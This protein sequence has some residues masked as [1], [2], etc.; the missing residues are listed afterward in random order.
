MAKKEK[1]KKKKS[2][3]DPNKLSARA[4][5]FLIALI[6][7]GLIFLPTSMLLF[8]GMMPSI[9]AVFISLRGKGARASTVSAMN[10]AGC[11]PY[12]FK[13]WSSGNDFDASFDIITDSQAVMVM[14][15]AAA[16]GYMIDWVVTGLV[17]SYLYQKGMN[18][19][20]VIKKRQQILIEQWGR[21]VAGAAMVS[22]EDEKDKSASKL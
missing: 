12:I 14:Y 9:V 3:S 2:G 10:I 21:E 18:R 17:S 8:V 6:L 4:R 13:L 19:M 16:F 22:G 1:K 20:K 15:T 7:L 5:I 11:I